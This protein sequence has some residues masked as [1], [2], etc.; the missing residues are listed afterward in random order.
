MPTPFEAEIGSLL[1]ELG[2]PE[3]VANDLVRRWDLN[4]LSPD[5][6]KDCAQFFNAAGLYPVFFKQV[7]NLT[8]EKA[9]IPWAQ[10][11]DA[12]GRARIKPSEKEIDAIFSGA[13]SQEALSEL[14]LSHQLD[15]WSR[16]FSEVRSQIAK[17]RETE[18]ENRRQNL[19]EELAFMRANRLVQEEAKILKEAEALFPSD[20]DVKQ[21]RE[22]F[23]IRWARDVIA[24]A[25]LEFETPAADLLAQRS[26]RLTP[27]Q[28]SAKNM[29]VAR[30][31]EV[32]EAQP[33]LAYDLAMS[34]H[35]M[36]F[37][38]EAITVLEKAPI[39][40]SADWLKLD[41]LIAARLFVDALTEASRL[42]SI[43]SPTDPEATFS[44]TYARARALKGLGEIESAIELMRG[45][46]RVRPGYKSAQSF[47]L[48]WSGGDE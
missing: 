26:E 45:L 44:A 16:R 33:M 29:I 14:V 28:E 1:R 47:L 32:A 30:A 40:P 25:N 5:E 24:K 15:I 22:A 2:S 41:L 34:L 3:A 6:Q 35:F 12:L 38:Q 9:Q 43:Y 7:R 21:D 31:L 17:V 10:F 42:E 20:Q 37:H 13:K 18:L 4:V 19:K 39:S 36:D 46:V 27:E 23:E 8:N 48:D 11:A